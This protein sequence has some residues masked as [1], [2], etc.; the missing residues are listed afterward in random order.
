MREGKR[1]QRAWLSTLISALVVVTASAHVGT[2]VP[3]FELSDED[4]AQ[5]DLHDGTVDDWQ[6]V[7]GPPTLTA[8]QFS[9]SYDPA[10]LDFRI[11]LAWNDASDHLYCAV[12][13]A[14]DAYYNTFGDQLI[15]NPTWG[16]IGHDATVI[17]AVDGDHSG[18]VFFYGYSH[19]PGFLLTNGQAQNYIAIDQTLGQ[20]R[21]IDLLANGPSYEDPWFLE[22]PFA[23]AGGGTFG[24]QPTISVNEFYVTAFDQFHWRD[25]DASVISDLRAGE[26]LGL[27]VQ[28]ADRDTRRWSFNVPLSMFP[29]SSH[30]IWAVDAGEFADGVLMPRANTPGTEG[31]ARMDSWARIKAGLAGG[32]LETE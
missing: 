12:E 3:I 23:D 25:K 8:A 7:V 13:R 30:P 5:I 22:P 6:D 19:D 16:F 2:I 27:K 9:G 32:E 1:L 4:V 20:A 29:S 18:G 14:D 24:Q 31:V 17:L 15:P 11:W 21:P 28:I 10:S 26:V